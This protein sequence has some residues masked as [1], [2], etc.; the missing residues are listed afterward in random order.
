MYENRVVITG[1]GLVTPIGTGVKKFWQAALNGENGVRPLQIFDATEFRTKTG[2]EVLDFDASQYLSKEEIEEM[3][4]SSQFAVAA[5]KMAIDDSGIDLSKENPFRIGISMGTTMGEPQIL[6]KGVK[7]KY[8][9]GDAGQIPSNL[10][11][12][13]PCASIPAN[14]ARVFGIKGPHIMIPTACAAGNYAI[15]Y[16]FDLIKRN[17]IDMAIVGGSDPFSGIAF[18]GFNRLLATTPDVCRPFDKNRAGMAV[19]EGSGVLFLERLDKAIA[20]GAEIYAEIIGYGLGCDAFK[21]TIPDP[22]GSGGILALNRSIKYSGITPDEID[23]ICA[24]GTG[25]GENDKSETLIVKS[26]LGEKARS[27]PMS[28]LKSMLGHT[29]GAASAIEAAACA[30]MIKHGIALPTINY[31]EPDPEC[32]LDYIPNQARPMKLETVV[33]NAYAFAGNTS[34]IVLR[35]IKG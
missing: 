4:R 15:G 9:T 27:T 8:Q 19:S 32:D 3:G 33:S 2:G 29:M 22:T 35:K 11:R 20:R 14:I 25:T 24:H 28:S 7:I 12:Q 6:E 10:P 13:Y 31:S 16:A 34:S 17:K 18:T 5:A 26:V 23:Y 21:M 30:L 1:L